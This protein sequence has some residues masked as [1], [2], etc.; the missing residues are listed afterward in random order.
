MRKILLAIGVVTIAIG[1][2]W[3]ARAWNTLR[4]NARTA[5]FNEDVDSLF[6]ALQKYKERVGSYPTGGNLEVS[7]ALQGNNPKNVIVIVGSRKSDVND[8]GEFVDPW[9]TPLRIYFSDTGV[10]IRSA[11][12]NRRFDDSTVMDADDFIRSN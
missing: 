11:G 5:Q 10:L 7:K 1:I 6:T 3:A 2:V 8:K 9:G 4:V 12:P